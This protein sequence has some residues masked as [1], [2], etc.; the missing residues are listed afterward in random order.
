MSANESILYVNGNKKIQNF[1]LDSVPVIFVKLM[2]GKV[3]FTM[4]EHP[5][6][7]AII[8]MDMLNDP[9]FPVC[10]IRSFNE[11]SKIAMLKF[12]KS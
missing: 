10:W 1:K 8:P 3:L 5:E 11:R 4:K 2:N 6:Y 7:E 12:T 9:L